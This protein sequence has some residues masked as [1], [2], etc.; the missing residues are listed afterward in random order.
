MKT[1]KAERNPAPVCVR[2][3]TKESGN[4]FIKAPLCA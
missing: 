3:K 2:H 4:S 1:D